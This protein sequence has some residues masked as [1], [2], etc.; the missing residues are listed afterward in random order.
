MSPAL[1]T[2]VCQ[3]D[4]APCAVSHRER[5]LWVRIEGM[6]RGTG[7]RDQGEEKGPGQELTG[8]VDRVSGA[9]RGACPVG[10]VRRGGAAGL[11]EPPPDRPPSL[12]L[13]P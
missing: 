12:V 5:G 4:S 10:C 13:K 2:S 8:T 11:A 1:E 6:G 3:S 9:C 7:T